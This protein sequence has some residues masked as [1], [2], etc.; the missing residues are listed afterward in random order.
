MP[1]TSTAMDYYATR[2]ANNPTVEAQGLT[3]TASKTPKQS[4]LSQGLDEA[5]AAAQRGEIYNPYPALVEKQTKVTNLVKE[6][7]DIYLDSKT[8]S[9]LDKAKQKFVEA[10]LHSSDKGNFTSDR[11]D[12]EIQKINKEIEAFKSRGL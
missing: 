5:N 3:V 7:T 2:Q 8:S 11:I 12:Y 9:D 1:N 4:P 10:K 6:G